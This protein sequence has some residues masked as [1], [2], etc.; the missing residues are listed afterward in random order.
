MKK[1]ENKNEI[2]RL[3]EIYSMATQLLVRFST[4]ELIQW[5]ISK[6]PCPCIA[7]HLHCST[8]EYCD[9]NDYTQE[10]TG[11]IQAKIYHNSFFYNSFKVSLLKTIIDT[12]IHHG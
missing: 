12:V 7:N 2:N 9:S 10:N 5:I 8:C 11:C 6:F 3:N 1:L 4:S